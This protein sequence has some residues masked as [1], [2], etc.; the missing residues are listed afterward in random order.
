MNEKYTPETPQLSILENKLGQLK[1]SW[2]CW[3]FRYF[4]YNLAAA[5][6]M[7]YLNFGLGIFIFT[8]IAACFATRRHA[9]GN[10]DVSELILN[11]ETKETRC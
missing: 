10:S 6:V 1:D 9:L 2:Q 8:W 11:T 5:A 4:I 7:L 3:Y